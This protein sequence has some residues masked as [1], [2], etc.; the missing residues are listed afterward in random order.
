MKTDA[1]FAKTMEDLIPGISDFLKNTPRRS[2]T[3]LGWTWHHNIETGVMELVPYSQHTS[4]LFQS[5]FHPGGKGGMSIW[6]K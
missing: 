1:E 3:L 6:G 5:L 4:P 2:P